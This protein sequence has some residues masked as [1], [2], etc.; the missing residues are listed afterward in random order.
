MRFFSTFLLSLTLGI[1]TLAAADFPVPPLSGRVVDQAGIFD[2]A[3]KARIETAIQALE[4][5]TQ[6]GQMAVATLKSLEGFTIEEAGIALGDAWKIGRKGR[7]DGAILIIVPSER[8]MRLEIGYGWEGEINDA[9]AGDVIRGLANFFQQERYADGAIYAVGKV[10]E[11]VTGKAPDNAPA[12]PQKSRSAKKTPLDDS[13]IILLIVIIVCLG[14][15]KSRYMGGN[16][17][18]GG[19]GFGGGFSGRSGGGFSGGGGSFGGGGASGR[20]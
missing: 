19:G 7:D 18:G 9:K 14:I 20:W 1:S 5:A 4:K 13:T 17:F 12:P 10:Q 15:L 16:R 8:R 6:G 3:G 11:Y 2:D